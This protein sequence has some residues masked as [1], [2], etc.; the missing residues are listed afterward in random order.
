[1][2]HISLLDSAQIEALESLPFRFRREFEQR[3]DNLKARDRAGALA[4][5]DAVMV[6]AGKG[7]ERVMEISAAPAI[8]GVVTDLPIGLSEGVFRG[9][10]FTGSRA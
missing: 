1:M 4:A 6:S 7:G 2:C 10:S 9:G 3:T 8:T 5:F